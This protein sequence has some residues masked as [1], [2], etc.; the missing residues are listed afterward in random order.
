MR[1]LF[2]LIVLSLLGLAGLPAAAALRV[3]S[4]VPDL[5]AVAREV[6]GDRVTVSAMVL[7]SQDPHFVDARPSLALELSKADALLLTGLELEVGWLPPL[8]QGSRNPKIAAGSPGYIDCSTF[9]PV[10]ETPQGKI[11][12]SQGDVHPGGN[13]HYMLDPRR[14]GNVAIGLAARFGKLDPANAA[15]YT[16]AAQDFI[17]RLDARRK[18]WE[19]DL[20]GLRGQ[21]VVVY[22]RSFPYLEDWVGF[23]IV[24]ELEPKPGVP[25]TPSRVA[26]VLGV[27]QHQGA[28]LLLQESWYPDSTSKIVAQKAGARIIYVAGGPDL[29]RGETYLSRLDAL[30][31]ALKGGA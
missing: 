20:A 11:D 27:A 13:P 10:L 15:A 24:A 31:A 16:A 22:H 8:I 26:E 25:P 2:A 21:P 7:H 18:A 5:A 19:A 3:V 28:R 17:L 23:H 29:G 1:R 4:T 30:V 6:G 9:V 14:A 12:R